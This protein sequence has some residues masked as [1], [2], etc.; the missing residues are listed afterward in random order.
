MK[1]PGSDEDKQETKLAHLIRR[2]W[3]KLQEGT[4]SLLNEIRDQDGEYPWISEILL[5]KA[6]AGWA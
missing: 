5:R 1:N 6:A 2:A 4:Q 3:D